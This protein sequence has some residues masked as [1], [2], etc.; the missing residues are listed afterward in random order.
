[1]RVLLVGVGLAVLIAG[2]T[3]PGTGPHDPGAT[4]RP[5]LVKVDPVQVRPGQAVQVTFPEHTE[6]GVAWVLEAET[7]ESWRVEYF[8]TAAVS[9]YDNAST[10]NWWSADDT[11]GKGWDDI[12]VGGPGPDRLV[13]PDTATPGTYRLCTANS[14]E[15]LCVGIEIVR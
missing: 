3:G 6:R 8:L 10:P 15:N 9:G 14:V 4:M 12:G 2:C 7:G 13:V 1:M 11:E 5:D